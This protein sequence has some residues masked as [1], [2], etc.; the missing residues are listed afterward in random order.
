MLKV[1]E[2]KR[3]AGAGPGLL[4]DEDRTRRHLGSKL[5]AHNLSFGTE[6]LHIQNPRVGQQVLK[7]KLT[8]LLYM[9]YILLKAGRVKFESRRRDLASVGSQIALPG[10]H[11]ASLL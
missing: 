6:V 3:S 8:L 1:F 5:R 4:T 2:C 11:R 7:R 10:A 9:P